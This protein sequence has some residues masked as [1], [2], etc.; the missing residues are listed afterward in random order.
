MSRGYADLPLHHGKVPKWLAE[1]MS[2]LGGAILET[3]IVE[4]GKEEIIKRISDPFW[5]Q[6]LGCVLGMDWHSSGITTSV[7]GA[8][9]RAM[10]PKARELG[11][12]I[13]GGRGKHSRN[14]PAEILQIADKTGLNASALIEASKLS[15]KVDNNLVQD[16]F[17]IYLHSFVLTDE[18]D[19]SVVQQGLNDA[20]GYARRYHWNSTSLDSFLKEPHSF[21]CGENQGEILNLTHS[22]ADNTKSSIV[23][24]TKESPTK[25]VL[26]AKKIKLPSHHDVRSY[27]VNLKRLGATLALAHDTGVETFESLLLQKGVGPRTIQSLTL[28]SEVIYGTASR[29]ED[30]A[31]F[32]FA[33]GGKD[34][35]PF[36]VPLKV[37]DE[38]ISVLRTAVDKAKIGRSDKLKAVAS[39]STMSQRIE[40]DFVPN[41]N[42]QKII[43]Q[44]RRDAHKYGGMTIFGKAE[45]PKTKN[46]QLGLFD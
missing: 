35:H 37:Y 5:F 1:R 12:Y 42:F 40:K 27:N 17:Q 39:L 7:M 2:S 38:S 10:N 26:E 43:E 16:G 24:M 19:W 33:H 8:L 34:G 41:T 29:F 25:M 4:Y 30:P 44:E 23:D 28:V 6:S 14:T 36:P 3:I 45:P 31:R 22:N 21:V 15:A 11:I 46:G 18:G 20:T 9:K 13:C 32:S